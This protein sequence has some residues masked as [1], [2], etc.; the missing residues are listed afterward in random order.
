M[1]ENSASD[2]VIDANGR[3]HLEASIGNI[4]T[5]SF[6]EYNMVEKEMESNNPMINVELTDDVQATDEAVITAIGIK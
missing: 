6:V 5:F 4:L 3:Y 2:T 1:I